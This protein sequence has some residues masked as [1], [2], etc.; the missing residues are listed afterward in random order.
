MGDSGSGFI[1]RVEAW[2]LVLVT[3]LVVGSVLVGR[4]EPW[5]LIAGALFM[6][7][8]FALLGFGIRWVLTPF[9]GKGRVRAGVALL[10]VKFFL[11]LGLLTVLFFQT[12]FDAPS[13]TV[14]IS[15][16]LGAVLLAHFAA[17]ARRRAV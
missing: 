5:A 8:N 13:L 4:I 6:G 17:P 11:F 15:S 2:H 10:V 3:L 16:L 9:A 7:I 1:V 14:G 12:R